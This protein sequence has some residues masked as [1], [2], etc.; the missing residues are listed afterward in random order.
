MM[1]FVRVDTNGQWRIQTDFFTGCTQ[2]K[3]TEG[4][5]HCFTYRLCDLKTERMD[6]DNERYLLKGSKEEARRIDT[7]NDHMDG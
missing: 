1:S 4:P 6:L 7:K 3:I 2:F 5:D